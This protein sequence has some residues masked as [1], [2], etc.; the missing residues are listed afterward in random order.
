MNTAL[1]EIDQIAV[2]SARRTRSW[3]ERVLRLDLDE[4]LMIAILFIAG[5]GAEDYWR[6]PW[7]GVLA[8]ATDNWLGKILATGWDLTMLLIVCLLVENL[9]ATVAIMLDKRRSEP[10]LGESLTEQDHLAI[11]TWALALTLVLRWRAYS[12]TRRRIRS[13]L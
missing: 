6:S 8:L 4:Q 13:A 2:R 1:K 11:G 3:N 5:V 12:C 10:L 9:I 7:R